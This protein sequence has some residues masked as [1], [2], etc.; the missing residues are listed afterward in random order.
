MVGLALLAAFSPSS[1]PPRSGLVVRSR[2]ETRTYAAG[3]AAACI[4]FL[5]SAAAD[6]VWQLPVFRCAFLLLGA[7]VLTRVRR[8]M[9]IRDRNR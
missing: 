3:A 5:V 1:S 8:H 2:Y 4:A 6:W 9:L 7:A